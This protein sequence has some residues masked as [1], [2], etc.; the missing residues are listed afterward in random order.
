LYHGAIITKRPQR[1][2]DD[3][4]RYQERVFS[5]CSKVSTTDCCRAGPTESRVV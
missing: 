4:Y 5:L 2:P 1:R 3:V